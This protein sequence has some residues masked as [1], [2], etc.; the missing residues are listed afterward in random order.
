MPEPRPAMNG[1]AC[2]ELGSEFHWEAASAEPC[3][4]W[5]TPRVWFGLGRHALIA[6]WQREGWDGRTLHVPHYFCAAVA[7][8]WQKA[9]M[10]LRRYDDAPDLP[11]PDWNSLKTAQGDIVLAVNYFGIRNKEP[12]Y[13]WRRHQPAVILFEDHTHD[14]VS[15]W[16]LSSEADYA[17]A[18]LRKTLPVPDGGLLWSPLGKELP[19]EVENHDWGPSALKLAG[20]VLKAD[21]LRSKEKD[22]DLKRGFRSLQVRGEAMLA[23]STTL[24]LS[25]W[26]KERL[27]RG[28]PSHWRRRREDNAR[29]LIERLDGVGEVRPL[30]TDW[31]SGHCPFN[32][33]LRFSSPELRERCCVRVHADRIFVPVHWPLEPS[34]PTSIFALSRRVLSVPVD[35]RYDHEDVNRVAAAIRAA[36]AG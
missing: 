18:S 28:V 9:G 15:A 31:P 33:V 29:L 19:Q 21:Y 17:F 24:S 6:V 2:W 4:A 32:V 26:S 14:P 36:V 23:E 11:H 22:A 5:P 3:I 7:A 12:W 20:M 35:Q 8:S 13:A 30:F 16:A 10:V 34:S 1:S 27:M 25:P